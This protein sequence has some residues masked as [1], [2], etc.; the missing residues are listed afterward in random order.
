MIDEDTYNALLGGSFE[1]KAAWKILELIARNVES[2]L[3]VQTEKLMRTIQEDS[4]SEHDVEWS[5]IK[6]D[7][8]CRRIIELCR[9]PHLPS[10]GAQALERDSKRYIWNVYRS[11]RLEYKNRCFDDDGIS[12][13]IKRLEKCWFAGE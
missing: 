10:D 8:A 4:F 5:L 12:Y 13:R 6:Y 2:L 7:K 11:I 1:D 9:I 3:N